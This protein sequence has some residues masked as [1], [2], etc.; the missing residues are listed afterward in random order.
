M[1]E[2][3]LAQVYVR[4]HTLMY[5]SMPCGVP[6]YISLHTFQYYSTVAGKKTY[7]FEELPINM[8]NRRY[9]ICPR[10]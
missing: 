5:T 1:Q 9:N 8:I 4:V 10:V 2:P 3:V 6:T 7:I